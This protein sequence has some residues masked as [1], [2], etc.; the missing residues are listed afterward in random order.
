M[1]CKGKRSSSLWNRKLP[2]QLK[3]ERS[4]SRV[5]N[6][7]STKEVDRPKIAETVVWISSSSSSNNSFCIKELIMDNVHSVEI[8]DAENKADVLEKRLLDAI[9][10]QYT[11]Q[12][13]LLRNTTA[14]KSWGV[15]EKKSGTGE[16][17]WLQKLENV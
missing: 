11:I 3:G 17:V 12:I 6:E 14:W 1:P 13:C 15:N 9:A 7:N 16:T 2:K 4:I 10:K 8:T 5:R